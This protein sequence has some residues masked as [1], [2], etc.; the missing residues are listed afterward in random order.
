MVKAEFLS[1]TLDSSNKPQK[2]SRLA[3]RKVPYISSYLTELTVNWV[4]LFKLFKL[5]V[6][7]TGINLRT[8]EMRAHIV[9]LTI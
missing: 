2:S 5:Q 6:Y 3:D 1:S 7:Y 8:T 4:K 9:A